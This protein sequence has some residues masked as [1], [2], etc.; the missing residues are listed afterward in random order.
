MKNKK[1]RVFYD[2]WQMDC[3]GE[4]FALGDL[5][6]WTVVETKDMRSNFFDFSTVDYYCE[7]H[8]SYQKL[9]LIQGKVERIFI[10]YQKYEALNNN[11][12]LNKSN[13]I[14]WIESNKVSRFERK[15]C[16]IEETIGFVVEIA[17]FTIEEF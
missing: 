13:K 1:C 6:T 3:C 7:N 12:K 11:S 17:D 8:S 4:A 5:I 10:L 2:T 16:N 14:K 15:K 9:F